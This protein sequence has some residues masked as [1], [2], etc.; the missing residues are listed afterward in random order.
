MTESQYRSWVREDLLELAAAKYPNNPQLQMLY[1]IGF[2]QAQLAQH[3][4]ND[5]AVSQSFRSAVEQAKN[6]N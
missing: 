1:Q 3:M 5:S 6:P 4:Y 2:L